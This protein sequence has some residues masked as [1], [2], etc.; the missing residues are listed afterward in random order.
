MAMSF[1]AIVVKRGAAAT[2]A[3]WRPEARSQK[4]GYNGLG[5]RMTFAR[6]SA[7]LAALPETPCRPKMCDTNL[8]ITGAKAMLRVNV[9][10]PLRRGLQF[11]FMRTAINQDRI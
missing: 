6:I 4:S 10:P 8:F 5:V 11:Y 9:E 3:D 1:S 7:L 2:V